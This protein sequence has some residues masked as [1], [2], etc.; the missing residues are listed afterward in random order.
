MRQHQLKIQ[1]LQQPIRHGYVN[2]AVSSQVPTARVQEEAACENL[3]FTILKKYLALPFSKRAHPPDS[4]TR[5]TGVSSNNS[6]PI[7]VKSNFI[8]RLQ[9]IN[10]Q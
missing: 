4:Y 9:T 10:L 8:H 3:N 1:I 7:R 2:V 5:K 6:L